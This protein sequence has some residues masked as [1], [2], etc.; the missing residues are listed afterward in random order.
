MAKDCCGQGSCSCLIQ[1][2][3]GI[4]VSGSGAPN[5]P[6]IVKADFPDF[7]DL[8]TVQDTDSVNMNIQGSGIE[9]DPF[10]LSASATL[11]LTALA[12]VSDPQ[13]G[14][15]IGEVPT[16]VGAG[17]A[18]HWEF[19]TPP[20]APAGA[21]NVSNGISGV[22]SAPD[23]IKV[24][25]SGVWGT[26]PLA[27]LGSDSTI[28]APIYI[29]SAGKVRSAPLSS[30]VSW[31]NVTGKPTEFVPAAHTHQPAD[32][33]NQDQLLGAGGIRNFPIQITQTEVTSWPVNTIWWSW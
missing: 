10:V 22:G 15:A 29:D 12:D 14:P 13:G 32:I 2:G 17:A 16:W 27:G 31:A 5:D 8:L 9:N 20:P 18:G 1:G 23:P 11:K 30:S 24:A 19:Q 21:V 33:L 6:Y 7:S 4:V 28:G 26:G 3:D 25:T